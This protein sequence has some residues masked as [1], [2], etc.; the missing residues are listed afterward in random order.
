MVQIKFKNVKKHCVFFVVPGNDQTLLRMPDTAA[1]KIINL[2]IESIQVEVAE[3]KSNMEQ[4]TH[5]VSKGCTNMDT[6][7]NTQGDANSQNNQ[8][9][10]NKS[11]IFLIK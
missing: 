4:E 8:N 10:M 2:N 3:C 5:T 1:L 11:I 9:N 7:V 6:G